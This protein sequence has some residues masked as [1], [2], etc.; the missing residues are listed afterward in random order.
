MRRSTSPATHIHAGIAALGVK[1][2]AECRSYAE[3]AAFLG[4]AHERQIAR[5]VLVY[6]MDA[7]RIA[8]RLY[9]TDILIYHSDETWE[10]DNGGYDT[11]TTK[12]RLEQ[13]GPR[14][15]SFGHGKRKLFAMPGGVCSFGTRRP[16]F[17]PSASTERRVTR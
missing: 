13:F 4:T 2:V 8:V 9:A 14:G 1:A 6:R 17:R 7:A 11:L 15:V 3:Y 5:N 10:A 12:Y 16:V